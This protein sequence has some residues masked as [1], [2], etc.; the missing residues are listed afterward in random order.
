[1]SSYMVTACQTLG[2]LPPIIAEFDK[3][4]SSSNEK[5][6]GETLK[7]YC[8]FLFRKELGISEKESNQFQIIWQKMEKEEE[9]VNY[10]EENQIGSFERLMR[11]FT[12]F[13]ADNGRQRR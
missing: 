5:K 13:Y 4:F 12:N 6:Q 10:Y 2:Q 11:W 1:M 3:I 7:G 9:L 8:F